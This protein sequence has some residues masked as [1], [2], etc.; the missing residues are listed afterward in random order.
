MRAVEQ[1]NTLKWACSHAFR[2]IIGLKMP[3][4]KN[5]QWDKTRRLMNGSLLA[6]TLIIRRFDF[7]WPSEI[8]N[9]LSAF[10]F[11]SGGA[12]TVIFPQCLYAKARLHSAYA[13]FLVTA[14]QPV[15]FTFL[16]ALYLL[17][18]YLKAHGTDKWGYFKTRLLIVSVFIVFFFQVQL[19]AA[20]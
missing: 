16:A 19:L 3:L 5:I 2:M 13:H 6:L 7:E 8:A 1:I 9:L 4:S 10:S 11:A 20:V 15:M 18:L 14:L 12:T 17:A